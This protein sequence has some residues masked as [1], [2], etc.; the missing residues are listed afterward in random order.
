ML[1]GLLLGFLTWLSMLFTFNH[2]PK[3]IK[4]FMLR[5]FI[6]TDIISI[7]LTF[8]FL[9]GISKSITSVIGSILCGLLV[10]LTLIV[11]QST[12]RYMNLS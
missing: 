5:H 3:K 9:S 4:N 12:T 7:A 8:L 6:F 10:N 1:D 2:L 11:S